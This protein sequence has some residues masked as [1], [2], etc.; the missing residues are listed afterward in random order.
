MAVTISPAI[1]NTDFGNL[2]GT[3]LTTPTFTVPANTFA[4]MTLA[5]PKDTPSSL[6]DSAGRTWT[7]V[8]NVANTARIDF[9]RY[10]NTTGADVSGTTTFTVGTG[11]KAVCIIS[12]TTG[13]DA[14][15]PM[16]TTATG[17]HTGLSPS[18][19]GNLNKAGG[20][21]FGGYAG[22]PAPTFTANSSDT[23]VGYNEATGGNSANHVVGVHQYDNTDT[24]TAGQTLT[25]SGAWGGTT[26]ISTATA[27]WE[28][29]PGDSGGGGGG[30][31]S[32][33]PSQFF[34]FF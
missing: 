34:A 20:R 3:S 5:R 23:L 30:G 2:D 31:T 17:T 7:H 22:T 1:L 33:A 27:G 21:W 32:S 15:T 11:T 8:T 19:S 14:A 10:V 28:I 6:S 18:I 9:W 29:R 13:F 12:G 26:N 4:V 16:G 24:G 25:V